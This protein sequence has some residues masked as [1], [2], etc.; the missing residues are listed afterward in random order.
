[1]SGI[2]IFGFITGVLCVYMIVKEND[3]NWL[4]GIINSI[5]L[6]VVFWK[7]S[8]YAQVGL[9]VLYVVEGF[10]GWYKWVQRDKITNKKIVKISYTSNNKQRLYFVLTGLLGTAILWKIFQKTEDPYPFW[11]S[12]ITMTSIVAELMLCWKLT[13]SW[14]I[15]LFSDIVAVILF[16][17]M[18]LPATSGTY[19]AFLFLCILGIVKWAKV[20]RAGK[21]VRFGRTTQ[22]VG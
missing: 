15:Y 11:D 4:I 19:L 6:L 20:Y 10:F 21:W 22:A 17:N 3:W 5:L 9:Q 14:W 13:E 8:L 16:Y 12:F 2:D 7:T 1:M 18:G